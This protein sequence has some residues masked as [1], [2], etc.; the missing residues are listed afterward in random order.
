MMKYN[1]IKKVQLYWES[2][3]MQ[4]LEKT[5]EL[6]PTIPDNKKTISLENV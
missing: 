2:K 1:S 4:A 6:I 5:L 3:L